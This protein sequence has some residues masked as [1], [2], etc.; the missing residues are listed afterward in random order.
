VSWNTY[1]NLRAYAY[2]QFGTYSSPLAD[3]GLLQTSAS[4]D[5]P[6][7]RLETIMIFG[8]KSDVKKHF[9]SKHS[10]FSHRLF[11]DDAPN[12]TT[13]QVRSE[14]QSREQSPPAKVEKPED[15]SSQS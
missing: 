9:S 6:K 11:V 8:N 1:L 13:G 7:Q 15:V 3:D 2:R 10:M 5:R 14:E 12:K 4:H